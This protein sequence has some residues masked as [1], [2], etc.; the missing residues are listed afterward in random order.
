MT[1][2]KTLKYFRISTNASI[3]YPTAIVIY[4]VNDTIVKLF[5]LIITCV[6]HY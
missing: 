5:K 2:P 3:Q 6:D 1:M 4:F